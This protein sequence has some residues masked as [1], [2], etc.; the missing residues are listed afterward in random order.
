MRT[1]CGTALARPCGEVLQQGRLSP[2]CTLGHDPTSTVRLFGARGGPVST[3]AV[4]MFRELQQHFL[5]VKFKQIA[6]A[7]L[8]NKT[9]CE[10]ICSSPTTLTV[11]G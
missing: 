7:T 4:D 3:T 11:K 9:G 2:A 6:V 8:E 1:L 5:C 10:I